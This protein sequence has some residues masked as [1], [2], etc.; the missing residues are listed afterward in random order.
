MAGTG[1]A[2]A[3][4]F[5]PCP[6]ISATAFLLKEATTSP[7]ASNGQCRP[8]LPL[9]VPDHGPDQDVGVGGDPYS[10]SVP[11]GCGRVVDLLK[12]RHRRGPAGEQTQEGLDRVVGSGRPKRHPPIRQPVQLGL[13]TG[14]DAEVVRNVTWPRAVAV[15]VVMVGF[16]S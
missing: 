2:K 13:V 16:P 4:L 15:N 8:R 1:Q 14:T 7:P 5:P 3:G 10:C 12:A 11:A 6:A 9:V